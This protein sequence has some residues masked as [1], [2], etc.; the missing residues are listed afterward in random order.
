MDGSGL[1]LILDRQ[2]AGVNLNPLINSFTK[3]K[4]NGLL[5]RFV[6]AVGSVRMI[7]TVTISRDIIKNS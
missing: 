4:V 1:K 3:K 5:K 7:Q 2:M 6:P